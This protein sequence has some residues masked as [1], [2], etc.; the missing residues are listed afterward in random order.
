MKASLVEAVPFK[1]YISV[2]RGV[3]MRDIFVLSNDAFMWVDAEIY[4][5][6]ERSSFDSVCDFHKFMSV[7]HRLMGW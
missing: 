5:N 6:Y 3:V 7:F 4:W 2:Q 1:R